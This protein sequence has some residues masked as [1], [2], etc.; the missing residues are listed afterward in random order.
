MSTIRI[1]IRSAQVYTVDSSDFPEGLGP[2]LA[3][4]LYAS[5][6]LDGMCIDYS[7]SCYVED[8]EEEGGEQ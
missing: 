5:G 3:F 4:E 2:N 6:E 7:E 8:I 1:T